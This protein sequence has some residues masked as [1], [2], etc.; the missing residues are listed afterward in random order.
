MNDIV[1]EKFVP[2]GEFVTVPEMV[3][4]LTAPLNENDQAPLR[5]GPDMALTLNLKL[6]LVPTLVPEIDPAVLSYP[7]GAHPG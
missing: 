1:P 7:P 5:S 2:E 6:T 3:L 4:P